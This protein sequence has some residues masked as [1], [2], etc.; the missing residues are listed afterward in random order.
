MDDETARLVAEGLA[1]LHPFDPEPDLADVAA[2]LEETDKSPVAE[3][4]P[5]PW[6]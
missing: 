4:G 1:F 2:L 6:Q 3:D 5:Q